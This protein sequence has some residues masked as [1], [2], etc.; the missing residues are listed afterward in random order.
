MFAQKA[1]LFVVIQEA[2]KDDW[3]DHE[4]PSPGR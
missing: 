4:T 3:Y 1:D 2:R